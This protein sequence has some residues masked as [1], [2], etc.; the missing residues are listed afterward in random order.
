[1]RDPAFRLVCDQVDVCRLIGVGIMDAP[2]V[3]SGNL[4]FHGCY[5]SPV[6]GTD[7]AETP[8]SGIMERDVGVIHHTTPLSSVFRRCAAPGCEDIIVTDEEG[9]YR[10]V[11]TP[12]DL[13]ATITPA[14]GMKSRRKGVY[15][16]C[17][18]KCSAEAAE[19]VMTRDYPTI[20]VNA[21]LEDALHH[22]ARFRRPRAVVL[23][24]RHTVVGMVRLCNIIEFL[25]ER[26]AL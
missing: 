23:D 18:L 16:D 4:I 7:I 2:P 15:V 1:M 17:L 8:V 10:G 5:L 12:M 14:I 13:L 25:K 20:S 11:I 19:D 3:S 26:G 22:M 9:V 24:D 6:R 21:T